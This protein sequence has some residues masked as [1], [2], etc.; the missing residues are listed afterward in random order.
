MRVC[1]L[2]VVLGFFFKQPTH[3]D[4]YIFISAMNNEV[5]L[6]LTDYYVFWLYAFSV[7]FTGYRS[8]L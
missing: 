1:V 8:R 5:V 4:C 6:T 7:F 2:G 3:L